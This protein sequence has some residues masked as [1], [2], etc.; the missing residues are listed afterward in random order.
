M[1][2]ANYLD[3]LIKALDCSGVHLLGVADL[4]RVRKDPGDLPELLLDYPRALSLGLPL[5]AGVLKTLVDGPNRLYLQHYRVANG[6]LEQASYRLSRILEE[7]GYLSCPIPAS[8][9]THWNPMKGDLSHKRIAV[10]AGAGWIGK[11]NLLVTP[12]WGSAVRLATVLTDCPLTPTSSLEEDCGT[13]SACVR[14]CPAHACATDFSP[15][16]LDRCFEWIDSVS[17]RRNLGQHICGICQK[18][19]LFEGSWGKRQKEESF[20]EDKGAKFGYGK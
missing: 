5:S 20:P 7:F 14:N 4:V 9:V 10:E 19:C 1:E 6:I 11:N 3:R 18:T 15:D 13:C 2:E 8:I 16:H 12:R 17:K